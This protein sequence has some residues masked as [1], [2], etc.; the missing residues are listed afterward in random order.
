[1]ARTDRPRRLS[2]VRRCFG[3]EA[4][5]DTQG[6]PG[7]WVTRLVGYDPLPAWGLGLLCRAGVGGR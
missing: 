4:D 3:A 5:L 2:T 1:M 6:A 7:W